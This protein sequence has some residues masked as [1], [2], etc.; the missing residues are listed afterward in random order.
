MSKYNRTVY[1]VRWKRGI[2]NNWCIVGIFYSQKAALKRAQYF[3]EINAD[4][5]VYVDIAIQPAR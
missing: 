1:V 3:Q 2:S 4:G 5:D